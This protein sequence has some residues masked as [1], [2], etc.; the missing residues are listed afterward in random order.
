MKYS[1]EPLLLE[2]QDHLKAG[3]LLVIRTNGSVS[4]VGRAALVP[5]EGFDAPHYFASY[6]LRLR[7]VLAEPVASW[8][9]LWLASPY[10]RRAIE[11]LAASS[12]GQ[13]NIG[14]SALLRLSLPLPPVDE[15]GQILDVVRL[16][17]D[18]VVNHESAL[19]RGVAL[20]TAQRQNILR[21][22]FSG[23]LVPQ[24]PNDEPASV[25]LE[26]IRAQRAAAPA[27]QSARR[28]SAAKMRA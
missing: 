8:I 25:L 27:K 13:H 22:A 1:V 19:E 23:Q 24:D 12:A 3:D 26:R 18:G 7:P 10:A 9:G 20:A 11:K 6:L 17:L 28:G 2:Q 14:L 21:A 16:R 5:K 15:Q 4:L